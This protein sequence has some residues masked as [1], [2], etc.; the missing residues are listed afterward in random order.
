MT[1]ERMDVS[2]DSG[3]GNV[4]AAALLPQ[5]SFGLPGSLLGGHLLGKDKGPDWILTCSVP[6]AQWAN[7][8]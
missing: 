6:K 8:L 2:V 7:A 4:A 5:S 3:R 1:R